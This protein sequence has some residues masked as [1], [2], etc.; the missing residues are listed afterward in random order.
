MVSCYWKALTQGYQLENSKSI[1]EAIQG[2]IQV[3]EERVKVAER[4]RQLAQERAA[5]AEQRLQNFHPPTS[6]NNACDE[7]DKVMQVVAESQGKEREL[8]DPAV[9]DD[10]DDEV[11]HPKSAP[12]K[13]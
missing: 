2:Q 11:I 8:R 13:R 9:S 7:N 10:E 3:L 12:V 5:Q 4:D 6:A 1:L